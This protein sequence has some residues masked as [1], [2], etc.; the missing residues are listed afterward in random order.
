M[1]SLC[2]E[3]H[4][5]IFQHKCKGSENTRI[6]RWNLKALKLK[7][8]EFIIVFTDSDLELPKLLVCIHHRPSITTSLVKLL[9]TLKTQTDFPSSSKKKVGQSNYSLLKGWMHPMD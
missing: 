1:K 2:N 8:T 3:G 5:G 6:P 9:T 7:R 4:E